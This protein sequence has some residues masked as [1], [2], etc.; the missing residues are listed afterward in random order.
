MSKESM[1]IATVA[2]AGKYL[3]S[4]LRGAVLAE[5]LAEDTANADLRGA[6]D[7]GTP[8]PMV[9]GE[10]LFG[11]DLIVPLTLKGSHDTLRFQEAVVNVTRSRNIVATPVLNGRGTVKEM[12]TDGDLDLTITLAVVSGSKD[13]DFDGTST[14]SYD[15]YPYN[16]VERLR[17]LLDEPERLDVVSDFLKL[18]DLDGGELGIVVKSYTVHQDTHLNRQVF[19]IQALSDYDYNLL[20]EA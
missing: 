7:E 13:G 10:D 4:G 16:G 11:R 18:F 17:K 2:T 1:I 20:I 14:E 15:V 5:D 9:S 12:I 19:E 8:Y 6:M 3:A